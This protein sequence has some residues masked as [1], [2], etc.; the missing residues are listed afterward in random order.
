MTYTAGFS[1]VPADLKLACNE[2][3]AAVV[4]SFD[5]SDPRAIEVK[6]GGSSIKLGSVAEISRLCLTANV[7]AVLDQRKRVHPA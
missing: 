2:G 5:Y 3:I 1:T 7:T 4:A 6:A